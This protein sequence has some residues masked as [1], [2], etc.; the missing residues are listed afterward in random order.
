M[1]RSLNKTIRLAKYQNKVVK[2]NLSTVNELVVELGA[3][4]FETH[5]KKLYFVP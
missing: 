4:A 5:S 3:D 1:I 2:S